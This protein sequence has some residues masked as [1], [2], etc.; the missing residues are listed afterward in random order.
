MKINKILAFILSLSII[1]GSVPFGTELAES[2]LITANAESEESTEVTEGYLTFKVYSDHAE[3]SGCDESAEGEII[4]PS[5]INGVPVTIIGKDSFNNRNKITSVT[6]SEGVK[7]IEYRAF[8]SCVNLES[9]DM[10]ESLTSIDGCAFYYCKSLTTVKVPKNVTTIG[11]GA[12]ADCRSLTSITILNPACDIYDERYTIASVGY[13]SLASYFN[14]TIYGYADSTAQAYAEKY[15]CTFE[16][17]SDNVTLSGDAN[18]DGKVTLAD[19]VAVLQYVA[20]K[21]KYPLDETAIANA[22]VYN[23]GDGLTGMDALTIQQYDSGI[24]S[25]F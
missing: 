12:F 16:V 15:G 8:Y 6:I 7:S 17:L 21:E 25:S 4:I 23:K 20:N 18:G 13:S 24:I 1:G 11:D 14:G 2:F 10:P 9:A 19:C 22:D 3:V 5:E